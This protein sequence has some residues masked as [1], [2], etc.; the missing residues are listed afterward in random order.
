MRFYYLR[1]EEK[2]EK[3]TILYD[4]ESYI[5]MLYILHIHIFKIMFIID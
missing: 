4:N 2:Y 1:K 5:M 3:K